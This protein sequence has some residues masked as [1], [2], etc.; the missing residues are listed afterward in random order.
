M[1]GSDRFDRLVVV[2]G[3]DF[4]WLRFA[5]EESIYDGV[6]ASLAG[7]EAAVT[8]SIPGGTKRGEIAV[9]VRGGTETYM[10]LCDVPVEAG[11]QVVIL[12]DRGERTLF[13]TPL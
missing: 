1:V 13:V 9:R 3:R 7:R 11:C 12:E 6:T 10:A 2:P 4:R 8:A 5:K